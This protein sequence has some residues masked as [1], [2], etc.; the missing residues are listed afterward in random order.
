MATE[1]SLYIARFYL[2]LVELKQLLSDDVENIFIY[3]LSPL[4]GI[5]TG[6]DYLRNKCLQNVLSP[7]SEIE[8]KGSLLVEIPV[9]TV[10]LSPLS[11]IKRK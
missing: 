7:L 6:K 11:G 4:S 5:E 2:H 8:T 9:R 10:V 1:N 3:V